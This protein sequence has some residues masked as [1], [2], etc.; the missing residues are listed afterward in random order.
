MLNELLQCLGA[1]R[2][3]I[4]LGERHGTKWHVVAVGDENCTEQAHREKLERQLVNR[5]G[6]TSRA[7]GSM[8]KRA[9]QG[10]VAFFLLPSETTLSLR[11]DYRAVGAANKEQRL[12]TRTG[13]ECERALAVGG[14]VR[15]RGEQLEQAVVAKAI[16]EPFDVGAG[17]SIQRAEAEAGVFDNYAAAYASGSLEALV[18]RNVQDAL[19][20]ERALQLGQINVDMYNAD[21]RQVGFRE[22]RVDL[23]LFLGVACDKKYALL[24]DHAFLTRI[25]IE[26][27]NGRRLSSPLK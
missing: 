15:V 8:H 20:V 4:L 14:A 7:S 16:E 27:H 22:N 24:V 5:T 13:R 17:Q 23:E 25:V 21:R 19:L 11:L 1:V 26:R 10:S 12:A 3:A 18:P 9:K 2:D 6:R